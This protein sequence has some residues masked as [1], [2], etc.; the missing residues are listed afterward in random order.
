MQQPR[1][2]HASPNDDCHICHLVRQF[3]SLGRCLRLASQW[4]EEWPEATLYGCPGLL[5]KDGRYDA[6]VGDEAPAAWLGEIEAAHASHEAV[7]IFNRPFF[8][9][10]GDVCFTGVVTSLSCGASRRRHVVWTPRRVSARQ[11]VMHRPDIH[12]CTRGHQRKPLPKFCS[13]QVVFFHRPNRM[14]LT[15]DLFWAYPGRGVPFGTKLW[16]FG[17]DRVYAPFYNR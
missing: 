12:T 17:M 7:P 13:L 14:L 16:K 11:F 9:E 2:V 8:S 10:V 6:E 4:K 1:S 3:Y 5:A 15:T